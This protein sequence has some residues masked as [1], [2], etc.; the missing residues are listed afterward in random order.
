MPLRAY[1]QCTA[2]RLMFAFLAYFSVTWSDNDSTLLPLT[3]TVEYKP[4]EPIN[5]L[6]TPENLRNNP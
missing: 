3:K 4:T 1:L 6:A 5:V 2:H